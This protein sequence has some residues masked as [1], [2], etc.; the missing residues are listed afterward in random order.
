[1]TR[2]SEKDEGK[3]GWE[4]MKRVGEQSEVEKDFFVLNVVDVERKMNKNINDEEDN[5][6]HKA[7]RVQN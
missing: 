3:G 7:K 5:Q 6:N 4:S 2:E 1:M